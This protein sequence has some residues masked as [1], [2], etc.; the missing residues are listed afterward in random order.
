MLPR[1]IMIFGGTGML[2]H[3]LAQVL[4]PV[5]ETIAVIRDEASQWRGQLQ[6]AHVVGHVDVRDTA[7][8]AKLLDTWE[9]DAVLNAAGVVKQVLNRA[10]PLDTM[11]VNALYPNLLALLCQSRGIRMIHYSTDCVF[12]GSASGERGPEGYRETDPAD[13]RDLYGM[14]KLLGEPQSGACLTLRTSI[15]GRELRGYTGLVEWFLAQDENAVNGFKH[16]LFTGLTTLEL[17]RL[18]RLLLQQAPLPG[19]VWHVA[20]EPIAKYDLL[21][22][23][24]YEFQCSTPVNAEEEFYCDRRLDGSRFAAATGWHAP[25]WPRMIASLHSDDAGYGRQT[26]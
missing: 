4:S 21:L 13:S 11:A 6:A 5:A 22:L 1:R 25:A 23:L 12:Q 9:P 8:L 14:S 17:A 18:T 16:A 19:G 24:K 7:G 20:A 3:K 2:G 10:D 15:I 26:R